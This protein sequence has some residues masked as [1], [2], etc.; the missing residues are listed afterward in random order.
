MFVG[1]GGGDAKDPRFYHTIAV[2][3]LFLI[4]L[5]YS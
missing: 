5:L 2:K 1:G 4:I 3:N